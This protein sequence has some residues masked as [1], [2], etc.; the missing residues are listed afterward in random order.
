M[1]C[2]NRLASGGTS[3]PPRCVFPWPAWTWRP[4]WSRGV[5]A[6]RTWTQEPGRSPGSSL[7]AN[8]S[9]S[10]LPIWSFPTTT[11][12]TCT[13][14]VTTTEE[15]TEDIIQVSCCPVKDIT[16]F[17]FLSS[18]IWQPW[19]RGWKPAVALEPPDH[20]PSFFHRFI[21]PPARMFQGL[22]YPCNGCI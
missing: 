9:S 5:R 15:C 2:W 12:T 7:Q 3:C 21:Y 17:R 19:G 13:P 1:K 20:M 14:C 11:C 16:D 18:D 22:Y 6:R 10:S 4:M 8:S